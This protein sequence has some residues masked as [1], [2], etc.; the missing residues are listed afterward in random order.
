MKQYEVWENL[1][2]VSSWNDY[3]DAVREAGRLHERFFPR[4]FYVRTNNDD[5]L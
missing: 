4:V 5:V 1:D 2:Y 3:G